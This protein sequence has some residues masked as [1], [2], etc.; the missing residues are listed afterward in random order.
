MGL[1]ALGNS[2]S[3]PNIERV[4]ELLFRPV[5]FL[6]LLSPSLWRPRPRSSSAARAAPTAS[7]RELRDGVARDNQLLKE[8]AQ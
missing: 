1:R 6:P 8:L 5:T 4:E 2:W 3:K 7:L